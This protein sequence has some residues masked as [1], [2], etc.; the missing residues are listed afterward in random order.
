MTTK[1]MKHSFNS[2][3][4]LTFLLISTTVLGQIDTNKGSKEKVEV[5]A[6]IINKNNEIKNQKSIEINAEN[7]FKSAFDKEKEKLKLKQKE[8]DLNNKGILTKAQLNDFRIKEMYGKGTIEK[9]DS[10]Q[11]DYLT[12]SKTVTLSFKDFGAIDGDVIVILH[13]GIPIS[14]S[15]ILGH[16]YQSFQITL[17]DGINKI[18]VLAINQGS[19]GA[20][21]AQ[22][23]LVD[24]SGLKVASNYWFLAT[25]AKAIFHITKNVE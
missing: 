4:L 19:L 13:D 16:N 14:K 11:G 3:F 9:V 8:E 22:Y 24:S 18:E 25:G 23:K 15:T 12:L 21:T 6:V 10:P 7:G 2:F 17:N 20:N 5:K 1:N